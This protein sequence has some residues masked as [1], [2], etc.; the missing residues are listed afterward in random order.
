MSLG[1]TWD[2]VRHDMDIPRLEALNRYW[3]HSPPVHQLVARYLGI[4]KPDPPLPVE[5]QAVSLMRMI[6]EGLKA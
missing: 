1:M 4:K 3:E 5:D 2:Q 6:D